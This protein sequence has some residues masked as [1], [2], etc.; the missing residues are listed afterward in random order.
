MV[1]EREVDRRP[2]VL[3]VEDEAGIVE[4]MRD[5]LESEGFKVDAVGDGAAAVEA[6][7][8][9]PVDCVLLDVMLPGES[10]F[11]VCRRL[12]SE[13]QVP[14][15]FLSAR[16][17]DH[18]RI[19]G[20]RLGADDYVVKSATPTEV[21]ERVKAVLRRTGAAATC[22]RELR[23]GS[24]ELD[25]AAHELRIDGH[26]VA[27]TAKEFELL[28]FFLEHP[29]QVFSREHLFTVLWG[30][31]GDR[32]VVGV[33]VRKLRAKIEPDPHRPHSLVTVWGVGYRFDPDG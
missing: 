18:D 26:E 32:S 17:D 7:R 5:F 21:V 15:V 30:D 33:Y 29:R 12:R 14:I 27:L 31:Y 28:R 22:P 23:V 13:S 4:L 11:E 16:G 25:L 1:D 3:L 24:L 20:L 10:G 8:R 9:R 19:R 6:L 2:A